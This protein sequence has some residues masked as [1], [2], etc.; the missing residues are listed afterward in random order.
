M[1]ILLFLLWFLPYSISFKWTLV[2]G[3]SSTDIFG[4]NL[5]PGARYA[6]SSQVIGNQAYL[7]GGKMDRLAGGH[8]VIYSDLWENNGTKFLW[9]SDL[10]GQSNQFQ[11]PGDCFF[12]DPYEYPANGFG[13]STWKYNNSLYLFG[14]GS[15][16]S[17]SNTPQVLA[18]LWVYNTVAGYWTILTSPSDGQ[19]VSNP[20]TSSGYPSARYGAC[21]WKKRNH[22]YLF[23][24]YS[25]YGPLND[26]WFF[27][28]T[29]W[30]N[31]TLF[32]SPSPRYYATHWKDKNGNFWLYG[33]VD[34]TG[35]LLNDT[36]RFNNVD[37]WVNINPN[38]NPGPREST[39]SWKSHQILYLYGGTT[40][41]SQTQLWGFHLN[42]LTWVPESLDNGTRPDAR[43]L[44]TTWELSNGD[45]Y[46]FGGKS[47]NG[48]Y[49]DVWQVN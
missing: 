39:F 8:P 20:E 6:A 2:S 38:V 43:V 3:N 16:V 23:G 45:V 29:A 32:L 48:S 19:C 40:N 12:G 22:F 47:V 15:Y 46:L 4:T 34:S 1:K 21:N 7:L 11:D 30:N 17:G 33:G 37:Y 41:I 24:G 42:N 5:Y 27:D 35:N 13:F 44:G 14:G 25:Q 28:G 10:Y 18:D 9:L 49:S 31:V 26:F 36:W